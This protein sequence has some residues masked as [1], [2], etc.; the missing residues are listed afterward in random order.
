MAILN[1][2]L[3]NKGIRRHIEKKKNRAYQEEWRNKLVP[4]CFQ[5]LNKGTNQCYLTSSAVYP[6]EYN[7]CYRL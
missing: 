6:S 1:Q 5:H 2:G 7:N 3:E 4:V